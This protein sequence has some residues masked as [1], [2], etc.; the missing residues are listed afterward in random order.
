MKKESNINGVMW[1]NEE[2]ESNIL[3]INNSNDG[4]S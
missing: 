3:I 4:V 2:E 1:N